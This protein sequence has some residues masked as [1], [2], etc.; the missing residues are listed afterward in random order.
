[1]SDYLSSGSDIS[2][3]SAG[4]SG[5]ITI[6]RTGSRSLCGEITLLGQGS[7][8]GTGTTYRVYV[9]RRARGGYIIV[10]EHLTIWEGR[11]DRYEA[12]LCK[13]PQDVFAGLGAD[14]MR[15][16]DEEAWVQA[17]SRDGELKAMSIIEI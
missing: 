4:N 17:C 13:S 3:M 16:A 8:A 7:A 10:R 14:D 15:P 9:A 2:K 5:R 6:E 11:Q 1:M 12:E